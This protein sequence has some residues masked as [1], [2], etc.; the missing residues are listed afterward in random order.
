[1]SEDIEPQDV[2]PDAGKVLVPIKWTSDAVEG[3]VPD[4]DTAIYCDPEAADQWDCRIW[5]RSRI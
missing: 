4:W 3:V 5:G 2:D 1:M